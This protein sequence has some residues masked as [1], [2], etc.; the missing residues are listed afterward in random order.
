MKKIIIACSLLFASILGAE[1]V[2]G[3]LTSK[4]CAEKGMF[5]DC[6]TETAMC[7]YEGCNRD[8]NFGDTPKNEYVLFIHNQPKYY[9][10]KLEGV[11]LAGLDKGFGR[12]EVTIIG[13]VDEE[14]KII[15][16]TDMKAPPP[17]KKSFFKGCL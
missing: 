3:F 13:E 15:K 9:T 7:G 17:P 1:E 16:A 12:N 8:W 2:V 4:Y 10:L 6:R 5:A 14:N 11:K